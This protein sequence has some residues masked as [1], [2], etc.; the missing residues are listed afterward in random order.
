VRITRR[1]LRSM[2]VLAS[3]A[4]CAT[5]PSITAAH[6][7]TNGPT[8][9][10][11]VNGQTPGATPLPV[12]GVM[13]ISATVTP[14]AN[15]PNDTVQSVEFSLTFSP[16]DQIIPIKPGQC[17]TTCTVT[18]SFDTSS[19]LPYALG[20]VGEPST[21]DGLHLV[22]VFAKTASGVYGDAETHLQIDNHRPTI[23]RPTG[24]GA[25]INAAKTLT[26]TVTPAV[27]PTA[28]AGTTISDVELE[29]PGT[30]LPVAHFTK[31]ADGTWTATVDTRALN[32]L[33]TV[34]AV[35][36]DS[37]GTIGDPLVDELSADSGFTLTAPSATQL[38]T[39]DWSTLQLAVSYPNY[40][41][42]CDAVLYQSVVVA[43]KNVELQVDGKV[44][45]DSPVGSVTVNS[46]GQCVIPAVGT[47]GAAAKP[48]PYGKHTLTWVV[49]DDHG[50]QESATEPVVVGQAL[51]STWP[52]GQTQLL[53]AGST[54]RLAPKVAAPDGASTLASWSVTDQNG[55][56][57]ASGTGTTAPSLTLPT[58]ATQETSGKLTLSL[59]SNLG[60]TTTRTLPYRTTWQTAVFTHL[61]ASTI[62]SGSW[63]KLSSDIWQR[64]AGTWVRDPGTPGNLMYEWSNLGSN[65]WRGGDKGRIGPG[66]ATVPP[67]VW[68]HPGGSACVQTGFT[69]TVLN[70]SYGQDNISATSAPVCVTV[71]P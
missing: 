61:S 30:P 54:L 53:Y 43:P 15:D 46:A 62:T 38:N 1:R 31:N 56:T 4:L 10:F 64:I 12:S 40:G 67:A 48:L 36:V 8:V 41:A 27:S 52:T 66:F 21:T 11:T 6:A 5:L 68:V 7:A 45:Q 33:Y 22:D 69:Q 9:A 13:N 44:W 2:A 71:K 47:E 26:W 14:D 29:A 57:L 42:A 16:F 25:G 70:T 63:V 39:G 23:P 35:A 59:V 65:V 37:N 60:I 58:S 19:V 32:G 24:Q 51:T 55:K 18:A 20:G 17:D 34:A 50:V 49:T 28:P 3:T